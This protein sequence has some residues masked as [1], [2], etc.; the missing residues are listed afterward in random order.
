[1]TVLIILTIV[2]A[3]LRTKRIEKGP[4]TNQNM[5]PLI[6][7][8]L[9]GELS[10]HSALMGGQFPTKKCYG[11]FKNPLFYAGKIFA[12][13]P[14]KQL[15]L[16]MVKKTGFNAVF[17]VFSPKIRRIAKNGQEPPAQRF[18]PVNPACPAI[19][20]ERRR[21]HPVSCFV[22]HISCNFFEVKIRGPRQIG[23]GTQM[24]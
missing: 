6:S 18:Y 11:T 22:N 10:P 5:R 9:R 21:I 12:I 7:R 23:R 2:I 8:H 13:L 20:S 3:G 24:S 19:A 15:S 4:S 1:M 14:K 17:S 16:S